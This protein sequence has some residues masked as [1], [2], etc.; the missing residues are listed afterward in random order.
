MSDYTPVTGAPVWF[1]LMT[2]D[3]PRAVDF[4]GRLF[5]W[6]ASEPNEEFGGYRNFS[7][8]GKLVAGLMQS[9]DDAQGPTNVWSVYFKVDDADTAVEAATA[10]GASVLSPVMAVGDLGRMAILAD[11]AG[12]AYGIWQSG[13]HPGFTE[14]GT[15]GT[16]YWF[17][18]MSMDYAAS[19]AFYPTALG[20][21]LTEIGTGGDPDAIGPDYYSQVSVGSGDATEGVAGIMAAKG[22][23]GEGHPS[24]WQV[25]IT[26]D[27][28]AATVAQAAELGGQVL[29]PGEVTPWGTLASIKDPMGAVICLGHPPAG[30]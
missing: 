16:P 26:V 7:A 19:T 25:Y 4:Y 11:P 24:F 13:T 2:S 27:D 22:M 15:H 21:E 17:D 8:H 12:A 23:L 18:T 5:G 10:A 6:E 20:W 30:R 9:G 14:R 1:D 3:A 28:V 29:M